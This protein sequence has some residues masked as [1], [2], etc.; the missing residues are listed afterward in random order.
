V[1]GDPRI[2]IYSSQ[3][4]RDKAVVKPG[5]LDLDLLQVCNQHQLYS[6]THS[7]LT[8]PAG[9]T[10]P[11]DPTSPTDPINPNLQSLLAKGPE[12]VDPKVCKPY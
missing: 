8:S 7:N 6:V 12:A 2:R 5:E 4:A 1:G 3:E 10:R 11:A 9:P